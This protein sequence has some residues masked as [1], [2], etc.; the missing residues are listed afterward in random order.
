MT[1]CTNES[2]TKL[3][4][5]PSALRVKYPQSPPGRLAPLP[6]PIY[7]PSERGCQNL[8]A[9]T[10]TVRPTGSA[11]GRS[12]SGTIAM[13]RFGT[14]SSH[15]PGSLRRQVPEFIALL[16]GTL[17]SGGSG[18]CN[19]QARTNPVMFR[20]SRSRGPDARHPKIRDIKINMV[21][22]TPLEDPGYFHQRVL[23]LVAT[24]SRI[25]RTRCPGARQ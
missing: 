23:D 18:A 11:P 16:S 6:L 5:C 19:A 15:D 2:W 17:A 3:N 7:C 13:R 14:S 8:A 21:G 20:T 24:R 9:G 12:A 25:S 10:A 4:F 22:S 1:P